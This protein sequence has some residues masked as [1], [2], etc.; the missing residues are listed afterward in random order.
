MGDSGEEMEGEEPEV[1]VQVLLDAPGNMPRGELCPLTPMLS[2]I[3]ITM[4][5]EELN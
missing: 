2:V 3:V 1:A 5:W 4:V